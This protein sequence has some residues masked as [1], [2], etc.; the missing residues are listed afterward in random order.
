[1]N[2]TLKKKLDDVFSIYIRLRDS[3]DNGIFRCISCGKPV[4]WKD[5]DN[6]H[7][8]N[9]QHMSLRYSEKNCNAQCRYCNRLDEGN[10]VGYHKGLISKYGGQIVDNLFIVKHKSNKITDTEAK[11]MIEY[12]TREVKFLLKTKHLG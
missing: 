6:G 4:F 8:I 9:R 12:Y 1:M 7:F 3:D 11:I 10:N 2:K 5:G